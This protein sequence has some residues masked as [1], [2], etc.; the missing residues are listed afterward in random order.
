MDAAQEAA[1]LEHMN[2][3]RTQLRDM[4]VDSLA[5]GGYNTTHE[6]ASGIIDLMLEVETRAIHTGEEEA[7][8]RHVMNGVRTRLKTGTY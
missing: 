1:H 4:F 6:V 2:Y 8:A 7:F 5:R 3:S